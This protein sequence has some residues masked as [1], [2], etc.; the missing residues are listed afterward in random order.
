M[1]SHTDAVSSREDAQGR[2]SF[3]GAVLR[4]P[5]VSWDPYEVWLNRVKR[6]REARESGRGPLPSANLAA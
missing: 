5:E 2:A 4:A 3:E 1:N 6:P